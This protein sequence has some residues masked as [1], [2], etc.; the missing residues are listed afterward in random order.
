[1]KRINESIKRETPENRGCHNSLTQR[2]VGRT[3]AT[4]HRQPL[5]KGGTNE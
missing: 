1:M 5:P 2:E 4:Y 3:I